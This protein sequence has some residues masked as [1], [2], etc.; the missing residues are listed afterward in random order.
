MRDHIYKKMGCTRASWCKLPQLGLVQHEL[1]ILTI[2][3]G[4][5]KLAN[6]L[7]SFLYELEFIKTRI[8]ST[9]VKCDS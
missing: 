2:R 7:D 5:S 4:N 8:E 3:L 1:N 9:Q 6:R